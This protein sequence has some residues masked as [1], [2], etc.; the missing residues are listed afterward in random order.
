MGVSAL[1]ACAEVL[2][3]YTVDAPPIGTEVE[4]NRQV[5][6]RG[7]RSEADVRDFLQKGVKTS[8]CKKRHT[9][10]WKDA[11]T[12]R[13]ANRDFAFKMDAAFRVCA[14]DGFKAFEPVVRVGYR[15]PP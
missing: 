5:Q 9:A 1:D 11:D 14:H 4:E 13:L 2:E 12:G 6:A 8:D 3:D 10:R 7:E 15:A